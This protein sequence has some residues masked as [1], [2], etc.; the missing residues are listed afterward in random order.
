MVE[1]AGEEINSLQEITKKWIFKV[2]RSIFDQE[3]K[4]DLKQLWLRQKKWKVRKL[5]IN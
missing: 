1:R 4:R 5:L 3:K 2:K